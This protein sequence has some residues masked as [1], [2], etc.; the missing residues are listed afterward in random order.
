MSIPEIPVVNPSQL[1]VE[2]EKRF[3]TYSVYER[4]DIP[5][6]ELTGFR[7]PDVGQFIAHPHAYTL[8]GTQGDTTLQIGHDGSDY[9]TVLTIVDGR[10]ALGVVDPRKIGGVLAG[11]ISIVGPTGIINPGETGEE[12]ALRE[13]QEET[14]TVP[15]MLIR[16]GEQ[17]DPILPSRHNI[18]AQTYLAT[19]KTPFKETDVP[20]DK[21]ERLGLFLFPIED[22]VRMYLRGGWLEEATMTATGRAFFYHEAMREAFLNCGLYS[23][24]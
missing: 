18:N 11:K 1:A 8:T 6:R 13:F 17:D 2:V 7:G 4:Y 16:M 20:V 15:D 19:V 23:P 5:L 3:G 9:V 22:W 12:A 21:S 10:Y 24:K 14:R